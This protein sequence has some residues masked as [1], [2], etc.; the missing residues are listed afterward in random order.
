MHCCVF[1]FVISTNV[2]VMIN[3]TVTAITDVT[4]PPLRTHGKAYD[5]IEYSQTVKVE[6]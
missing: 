1:C 5:F 2:A 4:H 6:L 3:G